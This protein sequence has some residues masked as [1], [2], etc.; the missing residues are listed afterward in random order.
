MEVTGPSFVILP[1]EP[2]TCLAVSDRG[3]LV[4]VI[5]VD[6]A[7]KDR[8]ESCVQWNPQRQQ[9]YAAPIDIPETPEGANELSTSEVLV[10]VEPTDV[11][12]VWVVSRLSGSEGVISLRSSS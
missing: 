7:R 2:P 3:H 8:A 6:G 9:V 5:G 10:A 1:T 4:V 12:H 11:N